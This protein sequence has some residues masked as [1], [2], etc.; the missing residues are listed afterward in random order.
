MSKTILQGGRVI[1]VSKAKEI[2]ADILLEGKKIIKIS[3][4]LNSEDIKSAKII[5]CTDKIIAPGLI[6]MNVHFREPGRDEEETIKS[7][8]SAALHGGFTA[9][10]MMADTETPIDNEASVEFVSNQ[11]RRAHS[12]KCYPVGAIT[13]GLDGERLTEMGL[14]SRAGAVAFSDAD[15]S[16]EHSGVMHR[17]LEYADMCGKPIISFCRDASMI[18]SGVMAAGDVATELGFSGIAPLVEE[19][20]LYR[21]LA[22]AEATGAH[23]HVAGISSRK[24]VE[25]IREAKKNGVKVT[26]DVTPHNLFLSDICIQDFNTSFKVYPPLRGKEHRDALMQGLVDGT[27]DAISSHH[28]PVGLEE[29]QQEFLA[30]PF[31]AIGLESTLPVLLTQ[32]VGRGKLTIA[33]LIQKLSFNPAKILQL[34]GG[35][36]KEG[37]VA[38]ITIIDTKLANTI[39]TDKFYSNSANCPFDGYHASGRAIA[40]LLNGKYISL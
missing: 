21:D 30:A 15:S 9:V 35:E 13:V 10:V 26:C 28:N 16:V 25:L 22:L 38:D 12:A 39:D 17:A 5:D 31:G 2:K 7:G 33:K 20:R 3:S 18:G 8:L 40:V 36:L 1:D 14:L 4:D 27:I 34:D 6:D 11:A 29:K 32:A 19:L 24:S 23:L 37:S